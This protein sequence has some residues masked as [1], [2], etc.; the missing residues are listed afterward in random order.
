[1]DYRDSPINP[2]LLLR[3]WRHKGKPGGFIRLINRYGM[4]VTLRDTAFGEVWLLTPERDG[5]E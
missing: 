4:D 5:L 1:M 2:E 3:A